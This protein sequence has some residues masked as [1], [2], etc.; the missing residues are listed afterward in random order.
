MT[1]VVCRFAPSPTGSLH[2]GN[3]RAALINKLL[4]TQAGGSFILRFDDTDAERSEERYVEGIRADLRWVGLDWSR[5]ERQSTRMAQYDA[6]ADKLRADG[7]LYACYETPDE[8]A[9]KR[10]AA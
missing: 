7:R 1:A 9:L 2:A 3:L 5:E 6:A 10:K 4:A 8:L